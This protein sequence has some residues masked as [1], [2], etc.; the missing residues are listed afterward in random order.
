MRQRPRVFVTSPLLLAVLAVASSAIASLAAAPPRAR[1]TCEAAIQHPLHVR[2]TALDPVRRGEPVRL[3]VVSRSSVPLHRGEVRLTSVSGS[4]GLAPARASLG[5]MLP[6]QE[7]TAEFTVVVP[8]Q[9]HRSLVE[10]RIE[11]EGPS[12]LIGRGAT[13]N[14][15]PDGPAAI[16]R[17]VAGADGQPIAEYPAR[18]IPR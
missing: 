2:V 1:I 13:F 4:A 17:L 14:L 8:S 16:A 11:G 10:F 9:G 7:S 3:R 6:G 18:R 5:V 12:G 15:L